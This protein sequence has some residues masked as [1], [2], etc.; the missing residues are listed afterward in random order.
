MKETNGNNIKIRKVL[1]ALRAQTIEDVVTLI[2]FA[3]DRLII[4]SKTIIST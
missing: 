4:G 1:F 2:T 3:K